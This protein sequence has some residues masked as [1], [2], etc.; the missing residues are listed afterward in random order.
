MPS[1]PPLP[2]LPPA[3]HRPPRRQGGGPPSAAACLTGATNRHQKLTRLRSPAATLGISYLVFNYPSTLPR[4]QIP[5]PFRSSRGNS[6]SLG[7]PYKLLKHL[8]TQEHH[9][10]PREALERP[11]GP[12]EA[13]VPRPKSFTL[14]GGGGGVGGGGRA[15]GGGTG[16]RRSSS[17][18]GCDKTVAVRL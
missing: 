11:T 6:L 13:L 12:A 10:T 17:H 14:G 2:T 4:H 3:R 7:C 8:P 1:P 18:L 9:R 5:P 15:G 16:P